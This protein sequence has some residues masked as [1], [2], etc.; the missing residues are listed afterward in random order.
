MNSIRNPSSCWC[1]SLF[2]LFSTWNNVL[3]SRRTKRT[4][5]IVKEIH[6]KF[7]KTMDKKHRF[8]SQISHLVTNTRTHRTLPK[9]RGLCVNKTISDTGKNTP[10]QFHSVCMFYVFFYAR[11]GFTFFFV[12]FISIFGFSCVR[13]SVGFLAHF[14]HIEWCTLFMSVSVKRNERKR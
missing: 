12:C 4:V 9:K 14:S 8:S 3:W 10:F 13:S 5:D 6:F 2:S 11:F 7:N 1:F